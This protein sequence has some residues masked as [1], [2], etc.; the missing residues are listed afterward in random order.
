MWES[1]TTVASA[2]KGGGS[3]LPSAAMWRWDVMEWA[4]FSETGLQIPMSPGSTGP[5]QW[6]TQSP[7]SSPRC[8][9][10][11]FVESCWKAENH[12]TG[13][14]ISETLFF[15]LNIRALL[16][17]NSQAIKF[18]PHFVYSS[19]SRPHWNCFH[20]LAVTNSA[21]INLYAKVFCGHM[22]P[23]LLDSS[24]HTH[25]HM[26]TNKHTCWAIR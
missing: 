5:G 25:I 12:H 7:E 6:D 2:R 3:F 8:A 24:T 10:S 15:F 16:K 18:K 14:W 20:I 9:P 17:S 22:F 21:A 26:H 11:C 4:P 19:I 23:L 13:E 1:Q